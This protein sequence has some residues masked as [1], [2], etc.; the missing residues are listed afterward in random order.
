L[1]LTALANDLTD[2]LVKQ[3]GWLDPA[4]ALLAPRPACQLLMQLPRIGAPTAAAILTAMGDIRQYGNGKPLV[5]LAGLDVRL[6][7]S[8]SSI[9]KLPH[10]SH[11]GSAYLRQWLYHYALRLVAPAPHC[12]AYSHRR[13]QPSPGKGAGQRA[14]LAVCDKTLRMIYRILTDHAPYNPQKDP[15]MAEYSAAQRTGGLNRAQRP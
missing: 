1:E 2:A 8:G 11:M 10:I 15:S 4:T 7:H 14:L 6:F 12:R 3:Q 5:K 9:R 13:K